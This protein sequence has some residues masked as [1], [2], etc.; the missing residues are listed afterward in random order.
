MI[1]NE[2]HTADKATIY[3]CT[4]FQHYLSLLLSAASTHTIKQYPATNPPP[5]STLTAWLRKAYW[6]WR[7]FWTIVNTKKIFAQNQIFSLLLSNDW[8]QFD[9]PLMPNRHFVNL[10]ILMEMI[11][12][13]IVVIVVIVIGPQWEKRKKWL[14][15]CAPQLHAPISDMWHERR[16]CSEWHVSPRAQHSWRE[17]L[18]HFGHSVK[19]VQESASLVLENWSLFHF[20][21][22]LC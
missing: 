9:A 6:S 3:K 18:P 13:I 15:Y 22:N 17:I 20:F 11:V 12:M 1:F 5:T 2:Y 21:L 10:W 16:K 14:S 19:S 8:V 4:N 7:L